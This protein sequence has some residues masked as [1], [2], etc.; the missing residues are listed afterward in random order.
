MSSFPAGETRDDTP[1]AAAAAA[2]AAG[3]KHG[4]H[5]DARE[6]AMQTE[7]MR[8][9]IRTDPLGMD[10]HHQRYWHMQVRG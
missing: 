1:D 9:M 8:Y 3:W 2:N 4:E 10:R 7:L 5:R 6:A